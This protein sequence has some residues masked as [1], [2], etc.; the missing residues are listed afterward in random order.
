MPQDFRH[1]T[2]LLRESVEGIL[3]DP[4]GI[5]VDC[6]L[7]GGGHSAAL[8]DRLS[9]AGCLVVGPDHEAGPQPEARIH[10]REPRRSLQSR[11]CRTRFDLP[12]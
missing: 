10:R 9:P 3:G 1:E 6:T 5:Y 8:V 2:V 12:A 4:D 7:G 11:L